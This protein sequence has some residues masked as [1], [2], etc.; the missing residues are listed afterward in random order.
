[1]TCENM[2]SHLKILSKTGNTR[3]RDLGGAKILGGGDGNG[4]QWWQQPTV[5]SGKEARRICVAAAASE[6]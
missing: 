5:P 2:S 6:E 4:R 3:H 1:M